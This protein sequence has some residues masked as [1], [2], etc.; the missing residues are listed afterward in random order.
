MGGP[1]AGAG[2][3]SGRV[4]SRIGAEAPQLVVGAGGYVRGPRR[5]GMIAGRWF[6]GRLP[7]AELEALLLE[8]AR[9]LGV[10]VAG[11]GAFAIVGRGV[12]AGPRAGRCTCWSRKRAEVAKDRKSVVEGKRRERR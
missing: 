2:L 7:G 5:G 4:G 3:G 8:H 9:E 6:A 12:H 1:G 11:A 10:H